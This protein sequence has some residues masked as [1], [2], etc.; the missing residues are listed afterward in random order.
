M[1]KNLFVSSALFI[2]LFSFDAKAACRSNAIV[3][4]TQ[5]D[6]LKI[7]IKLSGCGDEKL[8]SEYAEILECKDSTASASALSNSHLYKVSL[9]KP[10]VLGG[11]SVWA[12]TGK[13]G[14]T[15]RKD[16][17]ANEVKTAKPEHAEP[18]VSHVTPVSPAPSAPASSVSSS[19]KI[20]G[21]IDAQY[22]GLLSDSNS[23]GFVVHD[24]AIY[25]THTY[26]KGEAKLDIPFQMVNSGLTS[27]SDPAGGNSRFIVGTVKPQAYISHNLSSDFSAKIGQW[28]TPFGVEMNDTVDNFFARQG[29]TY[30]A[31]PFTHT[32]L[33]FNYVASDR[34]SLRAFAANPHDT[35]KATDKNLEYG[36]HF[37]YSGPFRFSF[38][39]SMNRIK[40]A[41]ALNTY[42]DGTAGITLGAFA[43]DAEAMFVRT[44]DVPLYDQ[45]F[46][47]LLVVT[48]S[49]KFSL[50][51]RGELTRLKENT[52]AS[53]SAQQ[54]TQL[55][56]GPSYT[57][58]PNAKIRTDFTWDH[59][60]YEN[61][62]TNDTNPTSYNISWVYRLDP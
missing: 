31:N 21:F 38:G 48:L 18:V 51:L 53:Q 23:N 25:L 37:S 10:E 39:G 60:D 49:E 47:G 27:S 4:G 36:T 5:C 17:S 12:V 35:G 8:A 62:A 6:N 56:F 7:K 19:S 59:T 54:Q 40:G 24:G 14:R 32:G 3:T 50:G 2:S 42:F 11:N 58:S 44:N 20:S 55:V 52:G 1:L 15:R 43:F 22:Q 46:L 9:E 13:V 16:V 61:P 33:I 26:G 45:R 41:T 30:T 57:L 34:I 28:D 29:L